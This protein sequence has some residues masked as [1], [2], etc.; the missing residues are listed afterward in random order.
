LPIEGDYYEEDGEVS[1][2]R[3]VMQAGIGQDCPEIPSSFPAPIP[4]APAKAREG[5]SDGELSRKFGQRI[6][7]KSKINRI[8]RTCG[9]PQQEETS[10]KTNFSLTFL[11]QV[12]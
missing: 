4:P 12:Y 9:I 10:T 2:A 7:S 5:Q 8:S 11:Q 3:Q 6:F 1:A